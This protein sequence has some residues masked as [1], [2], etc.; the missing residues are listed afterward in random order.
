MKI[1]YHQRNSWWNHIPESAKIMKIAVFLEVSP[2]SSRL[3]HSKFHSEMSAPRSEFAS[4]IGT[5]RST[6]RFPSPGSA[7][8]AGGETPSE[9][10]V[11][12]VAMCDAHANEVALFLAKVL[13]IFHEKKITALW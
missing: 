2:P 3:L 10:Y 6:G 1:K 11:A 4:N 9:P 8:G 5:M 7:E 13:E 12:I